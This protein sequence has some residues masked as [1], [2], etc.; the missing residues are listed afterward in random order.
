MPEKNNKESRQYTIIKIC[1]YIAM[2]IAMFCCCS[3]KTAKKQMT[4]SKSEKTATNAEQTKTKH[5]KIKGT[6]LSDID[7]EEEYKKFLKKKQEK[8]DVICQ[9]PGAHE[10]EHIKWDGYVVEGPYQR[11][12]T[13]FITIETDFG[14]FAKVVLPTDD[15]QDPFNPQ[16]EIPH[17]S[18]GYYIRVQ[19][20][21]SGVVRYNNKRIPLID[22]TKISI[23]LDYEPDSTHSSENKQS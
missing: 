11:D 1:V 4:Q 18:Y 19:G 2:I 22:D 14:N 15:N 13:T 17:L 8:E 3:E 9:K 20:E 12:N 6:G 23:N 10:F 7:E 16:T 21:I 5:E